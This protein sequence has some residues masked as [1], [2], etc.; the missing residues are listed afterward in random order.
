MPDGQ[1]LFRKAGAIESISN[2][3]RSIPANGEAQER[4]DRG[5]GYRGTAPAQE[6]NLGVGRKGIMLCDQQQH[7]RNHPS[8]AATRN[9]NNLFDDHVYIPKLW[10][11]S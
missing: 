5:P 11:N 10:M 4:I 7:A 9:I 8:E 1:P 2:E 3:C 6:T